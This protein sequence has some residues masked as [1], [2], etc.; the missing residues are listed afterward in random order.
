[1]IKYYKRIIAVILLSGIVITLLSACSD[2]RQNEQAYNEKPFTSFRDIPG[3]TE[4]EISDIEALQNEF[5]S[6]SYGMIL[7]TE[8]F[9]DNNGEMGGYAVLFCDW[10]T[11]LFDIRFDVKILPTNVLLEQLNSFEVDFSGNMMPS[12]E[13]RE[14]YK[15]TDT[16]ANRHFMVYRIAG[17]RS[18]SEIATERPLKYAFTTNAPAEAA[19]ANVTEPGTYEPVW[20]ENFDEA[21]QALVSGEADA[22]IASSIA[23][24]FF[25]NYP[26][27]ISEDFFPLIFNSVS[28]STANPA[29]EPIISVV[30]KAQRNGANIYLNYLHD[31]GYQQYLKFK[32]SVWLTDEEK[33]YIINSGIIPVAAIYN[34]YPLSFYDERTNQWDGVFFDLLEEITELT[35]LEF[36]V[37]HDESVIWT[38]MTALLVSGTAAFAPQVA[39]TR[40]SEA[41]F[42]W[43]SIMLQ[44]EQFALISKT[45]YRNIELNDVPNKK[46]G[47]IE[48]TFCTG[49]FVQW[50]PEH[51]N[52]VLYETQDSAFDAL[53]RDEVDLVMSSEWRLLYLTHYKELPGYKV[54][55]TFNRFR[56]T[57]FGFN[58]NE[59]LLRS[60]V[61]KTLS[62]IDTGRITNQ[63]TD[64]TYDFRTKV[65]E[66]RQPWLISA[67]VAFALIG[68]LLTILYV[69]H[70]SISKMKL[71]QHELLQVAFTEAEAASQAK[72]DFLANMSHEMR[73][74]LNAIIGMTLIGKKTNDI[75][76]KIHALNKIGDASSHLLGVVNDILD[77]AKIEADKLELN[78]VEYNF[79]QMVD[80][81]INVIHFRADEKHHSLV[82]NIDENIPQFIIGD[83]QRLAQVIANL[84][85]NAVK[86]THENG[87]VD[88]DITLV[89]KT[90][91][92]C[93]LCI[94]VADNGIG[95]S[96]KQQKKLFEA[97]EQ[98]DSRTN[99]EYGGTGLGLA[100]S[101]RIID[102]MGGRIM[103]DS[104]FGVGTVVTFMVNTGYSKKK[105]KPVD[106]SGGSD[107]FSADILT[108]NLFKDKNLLMAEDI[109]INREILIALLEG[110]GLNIDCAET[111]KEALDMVVANPEKYDIIFMDL[112]MPHMDGLEATRLI[113]GLPDEHS[114]KL[115][116]VAMTANVFQEDINACLTAGMNDHLGKPLDFDKVVEV[117]CT[118]LCDNRDNEP[119]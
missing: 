52:T 104:E 58:N 85:A 96:E 21:Y 54:N 8:S 82:V 35:G 99:R 109:E 24:A 32:L 71:R 7:S 90:E 38:D 31:L 23:D 48:N 95:I 107:E 97:F 61:D 39:R 36:E 105:L 27:I 74:P 50:F 89:G 9:I 98:A 1:M 79:R 14:M 66:E 45:E 29:L 64:K 17:S 59:E 91:D 81:V 41:H 72:S 93:E 44:S 28:M 2:N 73:T 92:K 33:A 101:K 55:L 87:K 57:R 49:L 22:Y 112:Q 116:I 69:R 25:I 56:E 111:G 76:D 60:I 6:L 15:M 10:L 12:P 75:A 51:A 103:I 4:Q 68:V 3:V 40:E 100:I 102:M 108:D 113:R 62:L 46:I 106:S 80:K 47:L 37:I 77:M 67:I 118:Y 119:E 70:R 11:E 43:S 20:I 34:N 117:L 26:D 115:P 13:R 110:S 114:R 83:N 78:P 65:F 5:E 53:M 16:I 19:V 18:L 63:W 30:T 86:F 42:I 94:K 84:L 88:L